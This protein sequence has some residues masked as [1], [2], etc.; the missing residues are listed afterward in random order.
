MSLAS[1]LVAAD[2][3]SP[4]N[5]DKKVLDEIEGGM[6]ALASS[7]D[8]LA[9]RALKDGGERQ[10]QRR[11]EQVLQR[12]RVLND[13]R[14]EAQGAN[15]RTDLA[16][17]PAAGA[18][19]TIFC[20]WDSL[21]LT[22]DG[23]AVLLGDAVEGRDARLAAYEAMSIPLDEAI[24]SLD[25]AG[26]RLDPAFV[27]FVELAMVRHARVCVLSRGIKPLIRGLLRAEGIGHVEVL[28][29][30]MHV[31][32]ANGDRW[33]VAFRDH[34]ES[35]H[36]KGESMRRALSGLQSG[37]NKGAVVLVGRTSCDFAPVH[38]GRVD[39]LVAPRP[40]ELARRCDDA[41]VAFHEFSGWE[42]LAAALLA[43]T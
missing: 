29:H 3:F 18:P 9:T 27:E 20:E 13:L 8:V 5:V 16:A 28:A 33:R 25:A 40:S 10:G 21:C 24:T 39:C 17:L 4:Q 1:D 36:D 19:V 12:H 32:R 42:A 6:A 7:V 11:E 35:G 31:D 43:S 30:D 26:V 23:E 15:L 2:H 34:S 41:G 38:A 14:A 22:G 37:G